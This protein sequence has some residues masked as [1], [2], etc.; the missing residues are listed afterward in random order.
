[1]SALTFKDGAILVLS[2]DKKVGNLSIGGMESGVFGDILKY[3]I[4]R[5]RQG[6]SC[7]VRWAEVHDRHAHHDH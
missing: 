6:K 7:G 4:R 3:L 1:M 5:H 2:K